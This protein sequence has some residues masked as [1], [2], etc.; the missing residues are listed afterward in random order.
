MKGCFHEIAHQLSDEENTNL[1]FGSD[2][3]QSFKIAI[4]RCFKGACHVLCTRQLRQNTAN[5]LEDNVG[6]QGVQRQVFYIPFW[7]RWFA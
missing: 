2:E 6:V 4:S 7:R 1:V 3:D 5:Y